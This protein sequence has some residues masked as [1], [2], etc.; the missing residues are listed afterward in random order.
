MWIV[1]SFKQSAKLSTEV[2]GNLNQ[3]VNLTPI[4]L[5]STSC[6]QYTISNLYIECFFT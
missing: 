2:K 5:A 4:V 1:L 3:G 6:T